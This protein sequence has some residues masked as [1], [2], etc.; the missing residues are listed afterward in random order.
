MLWSN[1]INVFVVTQHPFIFN[2]FF[3]TLTTYF[4]TKPYLKPFANPN[5]IS[6]IPNQIERIK[7]GYER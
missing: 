3:F 5:K 6:A 4:K 2:F 1:F 7:S